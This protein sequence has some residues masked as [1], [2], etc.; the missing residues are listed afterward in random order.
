MIVHDFNIIGVGRLPAKYDAPL[1]I[2][3]NAV[4]ST[5]IAMECFQPVTRGHPKVIQAGSGV[6]Y[7]QFAQCDIQDLGGISS[8]LSARSAVK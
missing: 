8:N 2:D 1:G 7:I 4:K 5:E 3:P 6:Q